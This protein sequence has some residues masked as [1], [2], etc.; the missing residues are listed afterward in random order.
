MLK[1]FAIFAQASHSKGNMR[2]LNESM[3]SELLARSSESYESNSTLCEEPPMIEAISLGEM[4]LIARNVGWHEPYI[5]YAC[6]KYCSWCGLYDS[7]TG[8]HSNCYYY[9]YSQYC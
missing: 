3:A 8:E 9:A 6:W 2:N 1:L 5:K 4:P 7:E